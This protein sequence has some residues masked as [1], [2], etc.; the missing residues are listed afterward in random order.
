MTLKDAQKYV[1]R[2]IDSSFI[3]QN[4]NKRYECDDVVEDL[5]D[6]IAIYNK[7]RECRVFY[8]VEDDV[9]YFTTVEILDKYST[10]FDTNNY[11]YIETTLQKALKI[12]QLQ[13]K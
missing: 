9:A 2:Y 3:V 12:F 11:H 1:K 7:E 6:L 13:K 4:I 10:E 8:K 5:K